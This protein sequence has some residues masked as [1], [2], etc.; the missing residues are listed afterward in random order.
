MKSQHTKA[1]TFAS[2]QALT[3]TKA[4]KRVC[5]SPTQEEIQFVFLSPF[6]VLIFLQPHSNPREPSI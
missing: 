2:A 3:K 5:F 6:G 1:H 4:C